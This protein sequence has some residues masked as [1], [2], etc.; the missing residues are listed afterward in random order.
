MSEPLRPSNS[1]DNKLAPP[2][3]NFWRIAFKVTDEAYDFSRYDQI[4]IA[5]EE[6]DLFSPEIFTGCTF[7]DLCRIKGHYHRFHEDFVQIYYLQLFADTPFPCNVF[8]F[9]EEVA[10]EQGHFAAEPQ[11]LYILSAPKELKRH[12]AALAK[13]KTRKAKTPKNVDLKTI[14]PDYEIFYCNTP[15]LIGTPGSLNDL[16]LSLCCRYLRGSPQQRGSTFGRAHAFVSVADGRGMVFFKQNGFLGLV[17]QLPSAS[18]LL[19]LVLLT[20]YALGAKH[21][22]RYLNRLIGRTICEKL[23]NSFSLIKRG[24]RNLRDLSFLYYS[25]TFFLNQSL[26][27]DTVSTKNRLSQE[28]YQELLMRLEVK[29]DYQLVKE[30][31]E[32][33]TTLMTQL[34]IHE[35]VKAQSSL[36]FAIVALGFFM[37]ALVVCVCV[38]LGVEPMVR[39]LNELGIL[40]EGFLNLTNGK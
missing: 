8:V 11:P 38:I 15:N 24:K 28:L 27:M 26:L 29:H 16:V 21:C 39:M 30:Q 4:A 35:V 20:G 37:V 14:A 13:N 18:T 1:A 12:I 2:R 25:V 17:P 19:P 5:A 31:I 36:R 32:P 10:M 22:L 3:L 6:Y 23:H 34:R 40:P 33:L 9:V 7:Y